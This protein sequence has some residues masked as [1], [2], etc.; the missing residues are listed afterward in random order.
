MTIDQFKSLFTYNSI[1]TGYLGVER[2]CFITDAKGKIVPKAH[3]VLSIIEDTESPFSECHL[4]SPGEFSFELAAAQLESRIGPCVLKDLKWK[5][6]NSNKLLILLLKYKGYSPLHIEV[7]PEDMP[8][9]VYPDPTGRYQKITENMPREILLAACRVIGTH[10]H[11]GMPDHETA[12]RVYNYTVRH[13]AE[14]CELGNGSFGERLAIYR[15]MAPDF[16]P[17]SYASWDEYYQAALAKGFAE[18]P[19]K[20]W[21]FIRISVHGTIEFRMFGATDSID[22]IVSWATRCHQICQEAMT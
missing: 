7:G 10:V 13:Y 12:L 1:M 9:D 21:T 18:D 15:Q 19:R 5:L 14:L 11:I 4:V 8:L 22:R 3:E 16:E 17:K 2:E 6:V 20:C